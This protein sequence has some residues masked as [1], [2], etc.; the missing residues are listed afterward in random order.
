M[1]IWTVLI[2]VDG[3]SSAHAFLDHKQP[4]FSS[5]GVDR[6]SELDATATQSITTPNDVTIPLTQNQII[7]TPYLTCTND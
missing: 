7:Q 6:T 4:P 5:K 3:A 2:Y 1:P